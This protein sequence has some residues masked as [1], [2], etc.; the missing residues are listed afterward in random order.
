M[1]PGTQ[2]GIHR[3]LDPGGT[4]TDNVGVEEGGDEVTLQRFDLFHIL[5]GW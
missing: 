1:P 2:V 3:D 4:K 5:M